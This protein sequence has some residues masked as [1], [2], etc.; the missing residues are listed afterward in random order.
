V[1][2]PQK[3]GLIV[4]RVQKTLS[5]VLELS[6]VSPQSDFPGSSGWVSRMSF[7][8]RKLPFLRVETV[9]KTRVEAVEVESESP[10]K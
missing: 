1:A 10:T 6:L 5:R 7:A 9:N 3:S 2:W 4:A 8:Q